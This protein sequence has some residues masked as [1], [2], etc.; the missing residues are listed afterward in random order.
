MPTRRDRARRSRRSTESSA[1]ACPPGTCASRRASAGRTGRPALSKAPGPRL[2][3][4]TWAG[5]RHGGASALDED[6]VA[7]A[8]VVPAQAFAGRRRGSRLGR[9]GRG[10]RCSRGRSRTGRSRCRRRRWRPGAPGAGPGRCRGRGRRS[11]RRQERGRRAVRLLRHHG[12]PH[13]GR[14][15]RRPGPD[16]GRGEGGRGMRLRQLTGRGRAQ[17]RR[18]GRRGQ[19][20]FK[21]AVRFSQLV[22]FELQDVD[23]ATSCWVRTRRSSRSARTRARSSSACGAGF[24]RLHRPGWGPSAGF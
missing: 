16:A 6:D 8:P 15:V 3:R 20:R 4:P 13:P 19:V 22:A 24:G 12:L 21:S 14:A 23:D 17:R 1:P 9:A 7:P 10:W 18:P 5:S 11:R 2:N